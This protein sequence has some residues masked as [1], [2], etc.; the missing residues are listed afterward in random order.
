M[1][2][3]SIDT[4]LIGQGNWQ[5]EVWNDL[6]LDHWYGE[7]P[8]PRI[9]NTS[10][11]DKLKGGGTAMSFR[12]EPESSLSPHVKGQP[13][14]WTSY[15]AEKR[16]I[17]VDY[18]FSAAHVLEDI[19][20]VQLGNLPVLTRLVNS[21][22]KRHAENEAMVFFST[23]PL[24]TMNPLNLQ[25]NSSVIASGRR[26]DGAAYIVNMLAGLRTKLNRRRAP[27][28]GRYVTVPPE[29][30]ELF[31]TCDQATYEISGKA[32]T[33]VETGE[34]GIRVCGFD[35]VVSEFVPN[36]S[37]GNI[38][39]CLYGCKDAIGFGRQIQKVETNIRLESQYGTGIRAL[40]VFGF[41]PL[42]SDALGVWT[43]KL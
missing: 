2:I 41:G 4:N 10:L 30:E 23:A 22:N 9:C 35:L 5:E 34:W 11:L 7:S 21:V 19:T 25:D 33:A 40:N 39:K 36:G 13:I 26:S 1:S 42:Y 3:A 12:V 20:E 32:S 24:M 17:T 27:K 28:K 6:F 15:Q 37:A 14:Q 29:V 16:Q 8:I 31:L 43:V 38:W 18:A